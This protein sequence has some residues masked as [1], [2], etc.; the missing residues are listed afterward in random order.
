MRRI[1]VIFQ[2]VSLAQANRLCVYIKDKSDNFRLSVVATLKVITDNQTQRSQL[3][4]LKF[5][6]W[7]DLTCVQIQ[8]VEE[9]I[10]CSPQQWAI[11]RTITKLQWPQNEINLDRKKAC[12]SVCF[13]ETWG[14]SLCYGSERLSLISDVIETSPYLICA[15][16]LYSFVRSIKRDKK[17]KQAS[18]F[19]FW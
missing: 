13:L 8:V 17:N 2:F 15:S 7:H 3:T 6:I 14:A 11:F 16:E 12:A 19:A 18:W 5:Q 4:V 1:L 9:L 10:S